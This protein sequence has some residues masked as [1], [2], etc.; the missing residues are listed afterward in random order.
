MLVDLKLFKNCILF[1]YESKIGV[2]SRFL[3]STLAMIQSAKLRQDVLFWKQK[4]SFGDFI[5]TW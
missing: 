5:F 3:P 4:M 2:C 1:V